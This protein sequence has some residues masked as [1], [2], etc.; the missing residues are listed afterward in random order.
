MQARHGNFAEFVELTDERLNFAQEYLPAEIDDE[1]FIAELYE[2]AENRQM[3]IY[4]V[5]TGE[6]YND[7][8]QRQSIKIRAEA[9]FISLLNFIREILDGA[10]L[11]SLENFSINSDGETNIL[12]CELEFSI[13]A[14]NSKI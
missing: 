5:Q 2:I 9:D 4:S 7:E 14:A 12:D 8:I 13:Y 3:L 6:I 10:R 1:K 11:V